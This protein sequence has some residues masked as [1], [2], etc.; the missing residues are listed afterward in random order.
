M[1][2][3]IFQLVLVALFSAGSAIAVAKPESNAES[4]ADSDAQVPT[5]RYAD[6]LYQA[7]IASQ[8]GDIHG[9]YGEYAPGTDK[10]ESFQC[11]ERK[12]AFKDHAKPEGS[13]FLAKEKSEK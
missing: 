10:C 9:E 12:T 4:K 6:L 7:A 1:I 8:E 13:T 3:S 2:I 5:R 11:F